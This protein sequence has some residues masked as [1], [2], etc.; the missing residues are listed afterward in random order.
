MENARLGDPEVPSQN[1]VWH[2]EQEV[3]ERRICATPTIWDWP[4]SVGRPAISL[5]PPG[6]C[7]C[8]CFSGGVC[9]AISPGTWVKAGCRN[10]MTERLDTG[11]GSC[12]SLSLMIQTGTEWPVANVYSVKKKQCE[13]VSFKRNIVRLLFNIGFILV[14]YWNLLC[15]ILKSN[16]DSVKI[17]LYYVMKL[18]MDLLISQVGT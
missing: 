18:L 9:T 17:C 16:S 12:M 4:F 10:M 3:T 13:C 7:S 8:G 1:Y 15:P 14:F 5:S 11:P 2:G 6:F